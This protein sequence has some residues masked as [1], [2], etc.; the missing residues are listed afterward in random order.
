MFSEREMIRPATRFIQMENRNSQNT[1]NSYFGPSQSR[2]L[3]STISVSVLFY[4]PREP[5][6]A[7]DFVGKRKS[8]GHVLLGST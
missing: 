7:N 1:I 4:G 5:A 8:R 2:T 3:T 6:P